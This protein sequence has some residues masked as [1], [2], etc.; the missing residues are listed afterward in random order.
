MNMWDFL[1]LC[2]INIVY[3]SKIN[4]TYAA[5]CFSLFLWYNTYLHS[6]I[7]EDLVSQELYAVT[8]NLSLCFDTTTC[9]IHRTVAD[10]TMFPKEKCNLT[11]DYNIPG[12]WVTDI[13]TC[14]ITQGPSWSYGSWIYNYLC[15]QCLSPL[16]WVWIQ[17]RRGV[18]DTTL[19]DKVCQWLATGR[20]FSPCTMVSST[21]KTDRHDIN[22]ILLKVVLNTIN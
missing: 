4:K 15:N 5:I 17:L 16:T 19:C 18:L 20:G 3:C 14:I 22:E 7:I 1:T 10:G 2:L 21:N 8:A 12:K 13:M 9:T 11:K 6:Y